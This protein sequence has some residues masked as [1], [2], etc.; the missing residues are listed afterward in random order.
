[1]QHIDSILDSYQIYFI[2]M[3]L[4]FNACHFLHFLI[5][6]VFLFLNLIFYVYAFML[7]IITLDIKK[8]EDISACTLHFLS[9]IVKVSVCV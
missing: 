9:L 8:K 3:F 2:W 7:H 1:M 4:Y 6:I 5:H